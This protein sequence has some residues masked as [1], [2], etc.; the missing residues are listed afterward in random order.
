M[1]VA[2]VQLDAAF[3]N[4]NINLYRIREL[5]Q[6]AADEGAQLVVLPE[7]FN[8][9]I[10]FH[11]DMLNVPRGGKQTRQALL[12]L[13][14]L[15]KIIIGGSFI[16]FDGKDAYNLFALYFPNGTVYFHRKDIPTQFE[17]CY[18]TYGDDQNIL[19]T[20]IGNI[21]I[22]LCW[23]MLRYDTVRRFYGKVDLVLSGACWWDL[24]EDAPSDREPLR[25]YN[26]ELAFKTPQKFATLLGVPV[27]H[28]SHCGIT[29][30]YEF[31]EGKRLQTRKFIGA[32][33]V[34]DGNGQPISLRSFSEG[35]GVVCADLSLAKGTASFHPSN[36]SFWIPKLP[37]AYLSAWDRQNPIGQT[38]YQNIA[39]PYYQTSFM[40]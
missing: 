19:E 29:K 36:K 30:S 15:H 9:S 2:A 10:G 26:H 40:P 34:I 25:R 5:V 6:K 38:Y 24:P 14:S 22:A 27:V 39:K 8:S 33:Q 21:G 17:N 7:F 20:P 28:A 32:T 18:F 1:K 35:A 4:V 16:D 13:S 12:E 31:P 23:E 3:A 37:D 11:S